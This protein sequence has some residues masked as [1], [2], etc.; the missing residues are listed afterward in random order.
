VVRLSANSGGLL[1]SAGWAWRLLVLAV[2]AYA[3]VRLLGMLAL[4][5]DRDRCAGGS[6]DTSARGAAGTSDVR[7]SRRSSHF[8]PI[9]G[10]LAVGGLSVLI[11][12]EPWAGSQR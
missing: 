1:V 8:V 7:S 2:A 9:I 4:V 11:T 3:A 6:H 5:A 12:W 10:A